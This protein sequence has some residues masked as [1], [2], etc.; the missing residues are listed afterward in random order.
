MKKTILSF[1]MA[2]L[3]VMSLTT[4]AFADY[5]EGKLYYT[6]DDG[7]VTI[8]GSFGKDETIT[9]PSSIAGYPVNTIAA[10]AF[11]GRTNLKTLNLPE[12]VTTVE[13]G[14]LPANI[15]VNY[16]YHSDTSGDTSGD[17]TTEDTP[18]TKTEEGNGGTVT[19]NPD[20]S[21]TFSVTGKSENPAADVGTKTDN[22]VS[23]DTDI[24][25]EQKTEDTPDIDGS[26]MNGNIT[27]AQ[28]T[29]G[30]IWVLLAII[31]GCVGTVV[32]VCVVSFRKK[33][34]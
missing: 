5:S 20:G 15:T 31:L 10:G 16:N 3:L 34:H 25:T 17:G 33:K 12:T 9:V 21:K 23:T 32:A 22:S 11:T 28:V 6:I 19:Q 18:A 8:T 24:A 4:N 29:G 26:L 13:E 7:S 27:A 14:A 1:V 2:L 30:S